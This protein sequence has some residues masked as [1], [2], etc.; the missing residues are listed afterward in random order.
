MILSL[1]FT[2]LGKLGDISCGCC[3][4]YFS[5]SPVIS[6]LSRVEIHSLD[7]QDVLLIC[8]H[9]LFFMVRSFTCPLVVPFSPW[10]SRLSIPAACSL[11]G[12]LQGWWLIALLPINVSS[13]CWFYYL[14]L[15]YGQVVSPGGPKSLTPQ[16]SMSTISAHS[17]IFQR[18]LLSILVID[19]NESQ[20]NHSETIVRNSWS[21]RMLRLAIED[22]LYWIHCNKPSA[23]R[24]RSVQLYIFWM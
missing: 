16:Q 22:C 14:V 5:A 3:N 11:L 1:A 17:A 21:P 18:F 12:W 6:K 10:D 8:C 7:R 24:T 4:G 20:S 23:V 13:R 15:C 2:L 19:G 9:V